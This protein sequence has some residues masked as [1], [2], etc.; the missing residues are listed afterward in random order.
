MRRA[1]TAAPWALFTGSIIGRPPQAALKLT[2]ARDE[3]QFVLASQVH[4]EQG[5]DGD[6]H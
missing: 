4:E 1:R 3:P 5:D 6:Q 2:I